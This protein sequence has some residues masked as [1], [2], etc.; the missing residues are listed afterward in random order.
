MLG[1]EVAAQ[2]YESR[3]NV[4]KADLAEV[5]TDAWSAFL[6]DLATSE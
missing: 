2:I 1:G 4:N 6:I 3:R 5:I